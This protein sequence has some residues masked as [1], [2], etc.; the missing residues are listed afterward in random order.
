MTNDSNDLERLQEENMA[1]H[2]EIETYKKRVQDCNREIDQLKSMNKDQTDT[3]DSLIREMQETI[4]NPASGP[5]QPSVPTGE[6]SDHLIPAND[7][8][9]LE[10]QILLEA[11]LKERDHLQAELKIAR[12]EISALHV[13]INEMETMDSTDQSSPDPERDVTQPEQ[14]PGSDVDTLTEVSAQYEHTIAELERKIM[15]FHAGQSD[16]ELV[17]QQD[18]KNQ[19]QIEA[20]HLQL[21][22]AHAQHDKLQDRMI[23]QQ[24]ILED[25]NLGRIQLQNQ[26]KELN[27]QL[28]LL[29][30]KVKE[31]AQIIEEHQARITFLHSELEQAQKVQ[32]SLQDSEKTEQELVLKNQQIGQLTAK[33]DQI[34]QHAQDMK[35][36]YE[37]ELARLTKN[38]S[39]ETPI[40]ELTGG[41]TIDLNQLK[42]ENSQ[43]RQQIF[44]LE[45]QVRESQDQVCQMRNQLA[46]ARRTSGG[47]FHDLEL[48][49]RL[50]EQEQDDRIVE[51]DQE[52]AQ[53]RQLVSQKDELIKQLQKQ[54][55]NRDKGLTTL[56]TKLDS[57]RR[58]I[59][60]V[61]RRKTSELIAQE[62]S[63]LEKMIR[64]L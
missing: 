12:D 39:F 20:L 52:L 60:A 7:K 19:E 57:I 61:A 26:N 2:L 30:N 55:V 5:D 44:S 41:V 4:F 56:V 10:L 6:K 43:L 31:Q 42:R 16:V 53:A 25:Y 13:Q 48:S 54:K 34:K 38:S 59:E 11:T 36:Q 46:D 27:N 33:L 28:E 23:E 47:P 37:Q 22:D 64:T 63:E 14:Q 49:G 29:Q 51:L 15:D 45:N 8:D 40:V 50:E 17:R 62:F 18:L 3:I 58:S 35:A 21:T 32:P 24:R 1:L 9:E